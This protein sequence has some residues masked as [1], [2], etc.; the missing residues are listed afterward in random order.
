MFCRIRELRTRKKLII[1]VT[2]TRESQGKEV[3][4]MAILI[5]TKKICFLALGNNTQE[6]EDD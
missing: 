4:P 6:G 1:T 3:N 5:F 2:I